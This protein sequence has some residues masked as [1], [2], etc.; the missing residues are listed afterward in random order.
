VYGLGVPLLGGADELVVGDVGLL[1][2]VPELLRHLIAELRGRLP[3]GLGR[4]LYL[5]APSAHLFI[6]FKKYI[7][8]SHIALKIKQKLVETIK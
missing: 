1:H 4:L 3:L 2:Q 8:N 7:I 5:R 6:Y